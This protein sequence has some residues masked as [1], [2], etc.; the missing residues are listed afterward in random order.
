[1]STKMDS[2]EIGELFVH[3]R[4]QKFV[5]KNVSRINNLTINKLYNKL[6]SQRST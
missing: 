6:E 1:M 3:F 2:R 5:G 4:V